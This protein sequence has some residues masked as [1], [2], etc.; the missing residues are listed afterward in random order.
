MQTAI[1]GNYF[2]FTSIEV[3]IGPAVSGIAVPTNLIV[4]FKAINYEDDLT[5]VKPRGTLSVGLGL[6]RG[7]YEAK[8]SLEMY[9]N[10]ATQLEALLGPGWRQVQMSATINYAPDD[11]GLIV[12]DQIPAFFL[13]R[14]EASQ[15]ESDDPLT[16]KYDLTIPGQ[17]LW[18]GVPSVIET[19]ATL[20][21]G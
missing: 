5:R 7:R 16:R 1:N 12:S 20:A 8:G 9:L 2:A 15:S 11:T 3:W 18:N 19:G 21:I 4:G 17:I 13:G 10:P 14:K 6:T